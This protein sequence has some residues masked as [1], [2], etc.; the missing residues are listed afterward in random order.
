MLVLNEVKMTHS[1]E[2]L[3]KAREVGATHVFNGHGCLCKIGNDYLYTMTNQ[4]WRAEFSSS[5][6]VSIIL[7]NVEKIDYSPLNGD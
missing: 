3:K 7:S 4:G 2:F 5:V 1:I 6:G